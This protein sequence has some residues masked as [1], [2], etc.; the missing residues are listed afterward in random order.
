M[1]AVLILTALRPCTI[2][3]RKLQAT[4]STVPGQLRLAG[5]ADRLGENKYLYMCVY[6][7][8][9]ARARVCIFIVLDL[10]IVLSNRSEAFASKFMQLLFHN[11]PFRRDYIIKLSHCS[12]KKKII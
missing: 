6:M 1:T 5:C 12:W 8:V 10:L 9:R 4:E 7:C 2:V 3:R 11:Y